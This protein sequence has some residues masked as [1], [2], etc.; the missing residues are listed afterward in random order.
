MSSHI[1]ILCYHSLATAAEDWIAPFTVTPRV[2]EAHLDAIGAAGATTM[3]VSALADALGDPTVGLPPRPVLV[4]FDDGFADFAGAAHPALAARGMA[5]T[6]YVTTGYVET[7]RGPGGDPMLDWPAVLGLRDAGVEM[8][9]HSHTHPQLDTLSRERARYEIELCKAVLEE[10]L[11]SRVRSFAYP[12]GYSSA[13][14]RRLVREA[15]YDSACAVG[16]ALSHPHDDVMRLARIMV[17][18]TT[19]ADD[20]AAW[21]EGFGA[22]VAPR[23]ERMR[24]RAWRAYRR[25][26]VRTGLRAE[27]EP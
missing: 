20:V 26:G 12:H 22:P 16:N 25:A 7:G 18:A 21:M 9:A 13:G 2:F 19:T 23:H 5:A 27:R 8:G 17:R 15:G 1:P 11:G 24:T 3:T 10:R 14:V 6:L 4:T